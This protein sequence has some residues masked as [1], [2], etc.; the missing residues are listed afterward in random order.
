MF[1]INF[2]C[3]L[4]YTNLNLFLIYTVVIAQENA[5]EMR[6]FLE[7]NCKGN[8]FGVEFQQYP[9]NGGNLSYTLSST[10][11]RVSAKKRYINDEDVSGVKDDDGYIRTGFLTLQHL[12]DKK[13]IET[14]TNNENPYSLEIIS[15]PIVHHTHM[16]GRRLIQFGTLYSVLFGVLLLS[17]FIVPL[18]EEKQDGLKVS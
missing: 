12:I 2:S 7:H 4:I 18:V 11:I 16:D 17:T 6:Y 1:Y 15:M 3:Y 5:K 8:C 9:K 14:V 13:Y 10:A